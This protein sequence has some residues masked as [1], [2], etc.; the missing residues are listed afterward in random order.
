M[1]QVLHKPVLNFQLL[2]W[3]A[4]H[5]LR[6]AVIRYEIPKV[7]SPMT[8]FLHTEQRKAKIKEW[9]ER[10]TMFAVLTLSRHSCNQIGKR[11][12]R[13]TCGHSETSEWLL[14][15]VLSLHCHV[16]TLLSK[17][18][19]VRMMTRIRFGK[20]ES[21]WDG[22][23]KSSHS[24]YRSRH[25]FTKSSFDTFTESDAKHLLAQASCF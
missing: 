7:R 24:M 13:L 19:S 6:Y 17:L 18:D 8:T 16:L 12:S 23:K 1:A 15:S 5:L 14:I 21:T 25:Y 11:A 3:L 9:L 22:C 10:W 2:L 4:W 20:S